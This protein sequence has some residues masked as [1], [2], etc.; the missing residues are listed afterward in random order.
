MAENPFTIPQS[1]VREW[2]SKPIA[3]EV[4]IACNMD[5]RDH[6]HA[7]RLGEAGAGL[8]ARG[9]VQ[10]HEG[11]SVARVFLA[12]PELRALG[13]ALLNVADEI[14]GTTPLVFHPPSPDGE[15][16]EREES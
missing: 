10:V 8:D 14:D 9:V 13:A 12:A 16:P 1:E 15:E 3:E 2:L 7:G 11:G 5:V 4:A 6:V